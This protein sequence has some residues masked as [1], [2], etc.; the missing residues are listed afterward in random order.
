M[1]E[2]ELSEHAYD[3][4]QGNREHHIY[5]ERHKESRELIS[6]DSRFAENAEKREEYYHTGNSLDISPC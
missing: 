5:A 2:A 6:D 3:K 1:T 4:V